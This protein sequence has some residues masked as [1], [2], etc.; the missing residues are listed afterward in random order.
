[1]N[2]LTKLLA[3]AISL[4]LVVSITAADET[5]ALIKV[6]AISVSDSVEGTKIDGTG[7]NI[8][9]DRLPEGKSSMS[10]YS[11]LSFTN[12]KATIANAETDIGE[13]SS[14]GFGVKYSLSRSKDKDYDTQ[15]SNGMPYLRVGWERLT[16]DLSPDLGGGSESD[17]GIVYGIGYEKA[18][19]SFGLFADYIKHPKTWEDNSLTVGAFIKF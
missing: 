9:A 1:M 12:L 8:I 5:K 15:L 2:N 19:E 16:A 18:F 7:L 17:S 6:G 14:I 13:A 11:M 4:N 10:L 3:I